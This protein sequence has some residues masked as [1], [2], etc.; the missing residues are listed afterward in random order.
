EPTSGPDARSLGFWW[1][2]QLHPDHA[3]WLNANADLPLLNAGLVGG[4][5][6]VLREFTS[7]IIAQLDGCTDVTDMAAVNYVLYGMRHRRTI[8]T[9]SAV[10]TPMWSYIESDPQAIW[11][12][13]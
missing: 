8:V 11:A 13:K 6:A 4:S 7:A 3:D 2:A 10:H 5:A 1:M 12:H 9:G